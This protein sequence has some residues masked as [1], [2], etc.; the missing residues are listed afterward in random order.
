MNSKDFPS[1]RFGHAGIV[2]SKYGGKGYDG[3]RLQGSFCRFI[4]GEADWRERGDAIYCGDKQKDGSP[5]CPEHH[6]LCYTR[7]WTPPAALAKMGR[8]E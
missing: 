5:Y 3:P 1:R 4:E 6:L 7:I 2:G 8:M